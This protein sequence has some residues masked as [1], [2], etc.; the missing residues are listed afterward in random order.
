MPKVSS[1]GLEIVYSSNRPAD[2]KSNASF[3]SFDVFYARRNSTKKPFSA[4]VNLG[5]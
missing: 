3:G 5:P 2:A 1:D 4:P